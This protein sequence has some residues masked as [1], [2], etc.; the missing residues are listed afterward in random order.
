MT[1]CAVHVALHSIF[2]IFKVMPIIFQA[3]QNHHD[4]QWASEVS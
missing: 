1:D 2:L 4:E 3:I